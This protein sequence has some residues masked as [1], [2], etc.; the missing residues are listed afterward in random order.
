M[1]KQG[2]ESKPCKCFICG[3]EDYLFSK[4]PKTS[5][6]NEKW[7]KQVR[8]SER[9]NR[10]SEE[11][12]NN[13]ENKNDQKIY[14]SM[15]RMSDNDKGPIRY[16]SDSSQFTDWILDSGATCHMTPQVSYFSPG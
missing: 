6:G 3:S 2:T 1:D 7:R 11:E 4:C 16:F 13:G 12:C 5:K 14:A 8:F 9:G 10:S 15:A